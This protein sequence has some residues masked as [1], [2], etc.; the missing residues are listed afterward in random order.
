MTTIKLNDPKKGRNKRISLIIVQNIKD[1]NKSIINTDESSSML[2]EIYM[3]ETQDM[4]ALSA[5]PVGTV[6]AVAPVY[7]NVQK[8]VSV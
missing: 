8:G 6:Y 5:I 1:T 3:V 2:F 4:Y 7:L